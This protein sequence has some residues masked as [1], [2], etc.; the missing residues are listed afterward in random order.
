[1][2]QRAPQTERFLGRAPTP[3]R[4]RLPSETDNPSL[5]VSSFHPTET[6]AQ[7]F[8]FGSRSACNGHGQ[9]CVAGFR[10]NEVRG[11]G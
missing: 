5:L 4:L 8:P 3:R 1:M 2:G 9:S 7:E 11:W 6:I 10:A